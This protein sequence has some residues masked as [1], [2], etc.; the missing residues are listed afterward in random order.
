MG[1]WN[2][3]GLSQEILTFQALDKAIPV[4]DL[5]RQAQQVTFMTLFIS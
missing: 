3:C 2:A 1:N 4:S 5:A